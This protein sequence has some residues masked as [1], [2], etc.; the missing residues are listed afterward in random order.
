MNAAFMSFVRREGGIHALLT[1]T[2]GARVTEVRSRARAAAMP[3]QQARGIAS[4]GLI[5]PLGHTL[6]VL[7]KSE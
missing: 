4:S 1:G 5:R 3:W 7:M 6:L 2:N